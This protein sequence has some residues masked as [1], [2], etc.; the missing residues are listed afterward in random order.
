MRRQRRARAR[1]GGGGGGF[2][3]SR[4][5]TDNA[6]ARFNRRHPNLIYTLLIFFQVIPSLMSCYF[7]IDRAVRLDVSFGLAYTEDIV[8]IL[9]LTLFILRF[10]TEPTVA[11]LLRVDSFIDALSFG[12]YLVLLFSSCAWA[13]TPPGMPDWTV[14]SDCTSGLSYDSADFSSSTLIA[15]TWFSFSYLRAWYLQVRRT[16]ARA[17]ARVRKARP[18][19]PGMSFQ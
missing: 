9:F 1:G 10:A 18:V 8:N 15:R 16:R 19:W 14:G 3:A 4:G 13:S 6:L 12:S 2:A 17:R 11:T 5:A 7:F